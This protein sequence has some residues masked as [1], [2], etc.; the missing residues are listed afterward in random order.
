MKVETLAIPEVLLIEPT[1]YWDDRGFFFESF[2]EKKFNQITGLNI[3]F[4]QDNVSYSKKGV[5]RGLH[6]QLPP[7]EQAKLIQVLQG[8][9]LDVAVDIR[10]DS[11]TYSQYVSIELSAENHKQ[12]FIPHGFAHGFL[13]LTNDVIFSYKCDNYYAPKHD[14]GIIYNDPSIAVNWREKIHFIVSQKDLSLNSL[15]G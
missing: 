12:L 10:K 4:V 1:I 5:L 7:F 3:K 15:V 11:P 6:F 8:K 9:V 13:A 14:S 2:N